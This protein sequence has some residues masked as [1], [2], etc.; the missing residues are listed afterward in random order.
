MGNPALISR[1]HFARFL[2]GPAALRMH[3]VSPFTSPAQA[4]LWGNAGDA[5][6]CRRLDKGAGGL[7]VIATGRYRLSTSRWTSS[8]TSFAKRAASSRLPAAP[9][10]AGRCSPLR[11]M[12]PEANPDG[13]RASDFH[14]PEDSPIDLGRAPLPLDLTPVWSHRSGV[15][16]LHHAQFFGRASPGNGSPASSSGRKRRSH[17]RWRSRRLPHRFGY[18]LG[19]HTGDNALLASTIRGWMGI[20]T[21]ICRDLSGSPHARGWITSVPAPQGHHA[22]AVSFILEG[23]KELPRRLLHPK[24]KT[25]GLR[26]PDHQVSA[27]LAET[28]EPLLSSTLLLPDDEHPLTDPEDIP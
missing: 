5:G 7:A 10:M 12:T 25:I 22:G 3:D 16:F 24:R 23:T 2:V 4:G 11:R 17:A 15:L 26:V 9:T 28:G 20:T 6:G 27:L 13:P 18:A 14:G 1:A 21:L 19:G 8:S